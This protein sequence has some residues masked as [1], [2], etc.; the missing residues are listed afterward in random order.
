MGQEQGITAF[1]RLVQ[2]KLRDDR[3][4]DQHSNDEGVIVKFLSTSFLRLFEVSICSL[5]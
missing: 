1:I 5:N 4:I 2:A 3:N